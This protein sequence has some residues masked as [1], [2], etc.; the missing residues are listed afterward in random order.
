MEQ[1]FIAISK[2][3]NKEEIMWPSGPTMSFGLYLLMKTDNSWFFGHHTYLGNQAK[4]R[5]QQGLMFRIIVLQ[6]YSI[7]DTHRSF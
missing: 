7:D 2:L 5:H 4:W 6:K 1:S 3:H